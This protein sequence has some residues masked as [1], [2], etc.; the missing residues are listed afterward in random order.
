MSIGTFLGSFHDTCQ[1]VTSLLGENTNEFSVDVFGGVS[2]KWGT[3]LSPS[4]V[5]SPNFG[6]ALRTTGYPLCYDSFAQIDAIKVE[7]FYTYPGEFSLNFHTP[8]APIHPSQP[9]A[10]YP[11]HTLISNSQHQSPQLPMDKIQL[12][13]RTFK[14]ESH[15]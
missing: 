3:T 15:N 4:D 12:H 8:Q 5:N 11:M 7:V 10:P 13:G 1:N 9:L 6:V 14:L 2:D